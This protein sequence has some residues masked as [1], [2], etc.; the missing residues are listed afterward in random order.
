MYTA[1]L[2]EEG[3]PIDRQIPEKSRGWVEVW[4]VQKERKE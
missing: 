1:S 3:A 4:L 2:G